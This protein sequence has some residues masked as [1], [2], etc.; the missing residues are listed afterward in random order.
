MY[1]LYP[2]RLCYAILHIESMFEFLYVDNKMCNIIL[3]ENAEEKDR[4]AEK[5]G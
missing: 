4:P 1:K 5:G 3:I 2:I